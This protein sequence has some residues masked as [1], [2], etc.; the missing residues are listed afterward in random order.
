[1]A[2]NTS[3]CTN[4]NYTDLEHY[5]DGCKNLSLQRQHRLVYFIQ[6]PADITFRCGTII[7]SLETKSSSA[8]Q[9]TLNNYGTLRF[10]PYSQKSSPLVPVQN[11]IEQ[12]YSLWSHFLEKVKQ[13]LYSPEQ[14][15]GVPVGWGSQISWQS[16]HEG[17]KVV[18]PT[19]RPPLSPQKIFLV[20]ISVTEWA[21]FLKKINILL[22]QMRSPPQRF[23]SFGSRKR[24]TC[25][26]FF[27]LT[28]VLHPQPS[29]PSWQGRSSNI[30]NNKPRLIPAC[31]N[32]YF[33]VTRYPQ[34]HFPTTNAPSLDEMIYR[35]SIKSF[36]DYKHLL[37]ENYVE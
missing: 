23:I 35:V 10:L 30:L 18:S 8:K 34:P 19:Y 9:G 32:N 28:C 14:A 21:S 27:S 12:F 3:Y 20:L 22:K 17:G 26:H 5:F 37:Q 33:T 13:S 29:H 15:L 7:S 11:L 24:K 36:P 16:A 25:M 31:C 4:R 6:F 1:M 2:V